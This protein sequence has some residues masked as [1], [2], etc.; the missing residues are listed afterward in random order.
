M[1][2][3]RVST[4]I[5]DKDDFKKAGYDLIDTQAEIYDNIHQRPV[6]TGE[7]P[8]QIQAHLGSDNLPENGIPQ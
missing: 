6:T 4:F 3:S 8:S 5:T 2:E 7:T 1:I